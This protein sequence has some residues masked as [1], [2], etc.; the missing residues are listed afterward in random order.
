MIRCLCCWGV[1]AARSWGEWMARWVRGKKRK[2]RIREKSMPFDLIYSSLF[3]RCKNEIHLKLAESL[4]CL[5]SPAVSLHPSIIH[6]SPFIF[7]LFSSVS[8]STPQLITSAHTSTVRLLEGDR[9]TSPPHTH[10]FPCF[11]SPCSICSTSQ[12]CLLLSG[13]L[14]R[15]L[16]SLY[17]IHTHTSSYF[18]L[19][20][21]RW[22]QYEQWDWAQRQQALCLWCWGWGEFLLP[23]FPVW[24]SKPSKTQ[25]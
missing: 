18:L 8:V 19:C 6:F 24:R 22:R 17:F 12:H 20:G 14:W 5:S 25:S 1:E 3:W 23:H 11:F 21:L 9:D 16:A 2:E 10:T 15:S 4:W 13:A 7:P